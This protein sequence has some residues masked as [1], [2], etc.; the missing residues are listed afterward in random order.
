VLWDSAQE[1]EVEKGVDW[2]VV[3]SETILIFAVLDGD[4]D[5]EIPNT[6]QMQHV[7]PAYQQRI[8]ITRSS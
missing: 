7:V 8:M 5:G 2:G 1:C 4:F 3:G 6:N